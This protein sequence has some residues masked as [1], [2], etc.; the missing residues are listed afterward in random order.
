MPLSWS[1]FLIDGSSQTLVVQ[2]WFQIGLSIFLNLCISRAFYRLKQVELGGL[3]FFLPGLFSEKKKKLFTKRE[4]SSP[5]ILQPR[6]QK[7]R[8]TIFNPDGVSRVFCPPWR[9]LPSKIPLS[10][11]LTLPQFLNLRHRCNPHHLLLY[12]PIKSLHL[13]FL[14]CFFWITFELLIL[15]RRISIWVRIFFFFHFC[16]FNSTEKARIFMK[17]DLCLSG[18]C[19]ECL[20]KV[21][22]F[23]EFFWSLPFFFFFFHFLT[24]SN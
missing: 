2:F 7:Q 3:G 4:R 10:I 12:R 6:Q 15:Q 21:G 19:F 24:S 17:C 1:H 14:L 8:S 9:L 20:W 11:A 16:F 5:P 18:D 22:I 23:V 13:R